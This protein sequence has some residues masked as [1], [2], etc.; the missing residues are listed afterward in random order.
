MTNYTSLLKN[1]FKRGWGK[2]EACWWIHWSPPH[3]HFSRK[4]YLITRLLL[5]PVRLGGLCI[6]I[7]SEISEGEYINS[8]KAT[9]YLSENIK[10]Q[11]PILETNR[12]GEKVIEK[13]IKKRR[14]EIYTQTLQELKGR[15]S[16][17]KLRAN[18]FAQLKV[19]S[20]WLMALPLKEEGY[21][22][23]K[24]VSFLM[25]YPLGTFGN[26]WGSHLIVNAAHFPEELHPQ[27][28]WPPT[29]FIHKIHR[30]CH[31]RCANWASSSF[32]DRRSL[33][34]HCQ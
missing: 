15:M 33:P 8:K 6:P 3:S 26:W 25:L 22:L 14:N 31:L 5:L 13:A 17:Y 34:C 28:P 18:D 1:L 19:A 21:T 30:R 9:D 10:T 7:F 2:V 16:K 20:S 12:K 29:W 27:E 23:N 11:D 32:I 4:T 24:R